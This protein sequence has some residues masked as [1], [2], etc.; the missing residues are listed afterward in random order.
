MATIYAIKGLILEEVL[1]NLLRES[2]YNAIDAARN[3]STLRDGSS[4]LEVKGRGCNHQI[5]AIADFTISPPFSYPIRLLLEAKFYQKNVGIEIVRNAVGVLKDVG[6]YWDVNNQNH[7]KSRYHY[8]YAIFTS[9]KFTTSAQRYA[10]A[11]DIYLIKLENNKYFKPIINEI[12]N[13][14][15]TDFNGSADNSINIELSELRK[16]LRSSLKNRE[17]NPMHQY[18]SE[19]LINIYEL[20]IELGA[21]YI[22]VIGNCFP[23]FLTPSSA[24]NIDDLIDDPMIRIC[25]DNYKWLI[26][27]RSARCP[28][29]DEDDILFSFDLPEE[30]FKLYSENNMLTNERALDLKQ[31]FMSTIQIIFRRNDSNI[32]SSL[33]LKLD[34]QWIEEIRNRIQ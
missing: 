25:W 3:D 11:Q 4:G 29:L 33:K 6:E 13:L 7:F 19:K 24:F 8:Q 31:D 5:D 12:N 27:K 18:Q 34:H 20:S 30:L 14:D 17:P 32:M 10:F 28:T 23:I 2:G 16:N 22:G 21:S 15:S 9:S 1:L 26:V